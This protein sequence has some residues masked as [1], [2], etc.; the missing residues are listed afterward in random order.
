MFTLR[1]YSTEPGRSRSYIFEA[2]RFFLL[3]L[4]LTSSHNL[5]KTSKNSFQ[6]NSLKDCDCH[7][8][9]CLS[10]KF[11][12]KNYIFRHKFP[13]RELANQILWQWDL[14]YIED[15]MCFFFFCP[16]LREMETHD[17]P[18][19]N[20]YIIAM[21]RTLSGSSIVVG[22]SSSPASVAVEKK[23]I[24]M[25]LLSWGEITFAMC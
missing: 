9:S 3:Q 13:T 6:Q 15:L 21:T 16:L 23:G 2:L 10:N 8:L 24:L 1:T 25:R 11:D 4:K 14:Q 18:V 19:E 12:E 5:R 22:A 7:D 20:F 17:I